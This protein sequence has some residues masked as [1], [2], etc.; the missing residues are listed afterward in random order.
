MSISRK[1]AVFLASFCM[2]AAAGCGSSDSSSKQDSSAPAASASDTVSSAAE[3]SKAEE[4]KAEESK[5][6]ESK[7]EESK[8]EE[9]KA[10]ES[11]A[12]E[13]T[14]EKPESE[15]APESGAENT[16]AGQLTVE[17]LEKFVK[18]VLDAPT[19][20]DA[21]KIL[22]DNLPL[23]LEKKDEVKHE[24]VDEGLNKIPPLTERSYPVS[25]A[26]NFGEAPCLWVTVYYDEDAHKMESA[27][28]GI[29]ELKSYDNAANYAPFYEKYG[30][31]IH[32]DSGWYLIWRDTAMGCSVF[33]SSDR[34]VMI[35]GT[36]D[37]A[38]MMG[39][40]YEQTQ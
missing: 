20:D 9:S 32:D 40:R 5:A 16:E 15:A 26:I 34:N 27:W 30:D 29:K 38:V 36:F 19:L 35:P 1:T 14:A 23:N 8:P 33:S 37:M 4:S 39:F 11:K 12:E 17:D 2:L 18:N 7:V 24:A 13:S 6:E 25:E 10:E 28:I 31:P 21:E 22:A 3:V